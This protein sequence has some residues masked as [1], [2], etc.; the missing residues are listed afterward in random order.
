M[1]ASP[2]EAFT[3]DAEALFG[4]SPAVAPDLFSTIISGRSACTGSGEAA[5]AS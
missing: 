4:V 1:A 2:G 5:V 3:P